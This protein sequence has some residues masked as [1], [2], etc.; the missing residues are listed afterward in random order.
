MWYIALF[1]SFSVIYWSWQ[2]G[3]SSTTYSEIVNNVPQ[4]LR[5]DRKTTNSPG[6]MTPRLA[7]LRFLHNGNDQGRRRKFVFC[8]GSL[9]SGQA[10][11]APQV[12]VLEEAGQWQLGKLEHGLVCQCQSFRALATGLGFSS[13]TYRND[14]HIFRSGRGR[15]SI[16]GNGNFLMTSVIRDNHIKCSRFQAKTSFWAELW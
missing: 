15:R 8:E 1:S 10:S 7:T 3:H 6:N 12:H 2:R 9:P 4:K 14:G 16:C 5:L 11:N 13:S